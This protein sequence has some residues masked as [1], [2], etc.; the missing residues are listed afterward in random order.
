MKLTEKQIKI[1][2]EQ[3]EVLMQVKDTLFKE[4]AECGNEELT[5][6]L[7][8]SSDNIWKAWKELSTAAL[9]LK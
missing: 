6:Y 1:I 7:S 2:R 5:S 3:Q 4:F 8:D 9:E